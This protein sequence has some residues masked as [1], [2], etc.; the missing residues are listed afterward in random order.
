MRSTRPRAVSLLAAR[1]VALLALTLA[2]GLGACSVR[3]SAPPGRDAG[4]GGGGADTGTGGGRDGTSTWWDGELPPPDECAAEARW[5]YLV[6][7]G[8]ALL[9]FEPDTV[10]I[11]SIGTLACA[12]GATPF[13]MAVDRNATA[14]VLHSDHRIYAA[15]TADASCTST[16][17]VPDQ[18]GLELFGMGFVS[19]APGSAEETLFIAGNAEIAIGSGRSTLAYMT[20]ADWSLWGIGP[21]NGS[22]ELTGTGT[23]ELWGFFPDAAPMAVRQ[24]DKTNGATLRQIDV[25][26][27]DSSGFG[28]SAWAFAFWGGRY[29]IFYQGLLDPS[30]SIWR[31]DPGTSAVELVRANIGYRIVGAGVSTCAPTVPF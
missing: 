7:S 22:P 3:M 29:Y 21:V 15:S 8:N 25:S 13:S 28:A 24:I 5:I 23:A 12:P 1:H 16:P 14:Y 19:N 20:T 11:S 17:F 18:M 26:V 31:V 30:T 10:T 2:T 9:R 6:D 27:V 4:G